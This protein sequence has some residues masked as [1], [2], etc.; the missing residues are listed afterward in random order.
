MT[1]MPVDLNDVAWDIGRRRSLPNG[2]GQRAMEKPAMKPPE[3][4]STFASGV[5]HHPACLGHA[6]LV[7]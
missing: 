6:D 7:G 4:A 2:H 5:S 3:N 1:G